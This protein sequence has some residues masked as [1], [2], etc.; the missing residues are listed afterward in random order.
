VFE[1]FDLDSHVGHAEDVVD[2]GIEIEGGVV[3]LG[4]DPGLGARPRAE[5]LASLPMIEI[6]S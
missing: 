5:F 6:E 2:G 3:R 1:Y 4:S